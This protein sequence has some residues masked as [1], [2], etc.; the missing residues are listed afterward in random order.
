MR[1]KTTTMSLLNLPNEIILQIARDQTI[2]DLRSFLITNRRF[3]RLLN[4]SLV[5]AVFRDR[6][7][8]HGKRLLLHTARTG[9]VAAIS[10]LLD[11]EILRFTGDDALLNNAVVTE[12]GFAVR[13]LIE[14]GINVNSK[15]EKTGDTPLMRAIWNGNEN[16][17][18]MLLEYRDVDVNCWNDNRE[19]AFHLA[20]VHGSEGMVKA[21]LEREELEVNVENKFS[22][23]PIHV[24]VG[25][26]QV[27]MVKALLADPRLEINVL[28]HDRWTPLHC[29]VRRGVDEIVRLLLEDGRLDINATCAPRGNDALALAIY[30]GHASIVEML[31]DD[32]RTEAKLSA[33]VEE[34]NIGTGR[35]VERVLQ[36]RG[37]LGP[38]RRKASPKP[39]EESSV[40]EGKRLKSGEEPMPSGEPQDPGS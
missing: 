36:S 2:R 34:W 35:K 3:A 29:A 37:L 17:V 18:R 26:G 19:A 33:K 1:K 6:S 7:A 13:T 38:K 27:G 22:W 31:L 39:M 21:F 24:V 8:I 10:K 32:K 14:A 40:S 4:E 16:M 15:E 23:R 20:C 9:N 28:G 5:D 11:R 25:R 12:P 30:E